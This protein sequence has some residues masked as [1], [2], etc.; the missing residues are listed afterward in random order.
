MPDAGDLRVVIVAADPLARAGLA[1]MLSEEPGLAVLG[2]LLPPEDPA[3][4][5]AVFEPDAV[6]WDIGW[7][8]EAA[9][10]DGLRD[11]AV[12]VIFLLPEAAH[13]EDLLSGQPRGLLSR[14]ADGSAIS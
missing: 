2:R 3:R 1:A 4:E 6:L 10:P 12:P 14:D 7:D 8:A 9:Y 13:L 5:L 11:I